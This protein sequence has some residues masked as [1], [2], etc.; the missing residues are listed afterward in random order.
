MV[1]PSATLHLVVDP[2][3]PLAMPDIKFLGAEQ[4]VAPLRKALVEN[5]E[6]W[7]E[8][9]PLLTNLE[10]LLDL[11][12]PARS[13]NLNSFPEFSLTSPC[14]PGMRREVRTGVLS[15]ASVTRSYLASNCQQSP[16]KIYAAANPSIP[17]VFMSTFR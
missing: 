7:A 12:L 1:A 14:L 6:S 9:E 16:V 8:D 4:R 13:L 11:T 5:V 3:S 10:H 15:V 17:P 2:A